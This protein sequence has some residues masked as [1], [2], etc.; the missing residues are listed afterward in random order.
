MESGSAPL[1]M[2]WVGIEQVIAE[3]VS[4]IELERLVLQ[5]TEYYGFV[6]ILS[7]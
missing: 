5:T 7:R 2:V 4:Y 1:V 3:P 6:E